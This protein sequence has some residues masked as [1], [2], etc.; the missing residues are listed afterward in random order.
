MFNKYIGIVAQM[1][2]RANNNKLLGALM[3]L[4]MTILN[5]PNHKISYSNKNTQ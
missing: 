3:V 2:E 5:F 1:V 4:D